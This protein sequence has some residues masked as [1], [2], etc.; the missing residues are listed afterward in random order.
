MTFQFKAGEF[1]QNNPFILPEMVDYV[2][3]TAAASGARYLV[4]AYCGVGLFTLSAA[5]LFD[6]VVGVE[7]SQAS[8]LWAQA[9][10]RIGG[11]DNAR[12][13]IG[14]AEAIFRDLKF[15]PA[16]TAMIIDP[17]RK[18]CD[19]NFRRQLLEYRPQRL[20]YVSCDPATQ[21]RD[22]E[23]CIG[24]GYRISRI[25]PFDLFPHT[26]HIENIVSLDLDG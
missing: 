20:V 25:Q 3:T 7:I 21:A 15:P 2:T 10:A 12:F 4:D 13:L 9:N 16:E 1:F 11:I 22:L 19:E 23:Y 6:Q 26:R 24:G 5:K 17:P 18:G 14:K 8:V